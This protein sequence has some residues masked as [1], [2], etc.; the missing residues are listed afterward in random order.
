MAQRMSNHQSFLLMRASPPRSRQMIV[1]MIAAPAIRKAER[2]NTG[3]TRKTIF[4]G[5]PQVPKMSCTAMR[6]RCGPAPIFRVVWLM[7]TS[8]GGKHTKD[9]EVVE[10]RAAIDQG[11][12]KLDSP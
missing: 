1:S 5:I 11:I 4:P 10:A 12:D 3:I 2:P 9:W 7:R 8:E 6:A